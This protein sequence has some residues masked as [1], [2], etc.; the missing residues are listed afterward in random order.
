[1]SILDAKL[2]FDD[3]A[4]LSCSS[5]ETNVSQ[6]VIRL[7]ALSATMKDAWGTE[8]SPDIG[9]GNNGLQV[10]VQVAT[11]FNASNSFTAKIYHHT[12]STFSAGELMGTLVFGSSGAAAPA[13][14]AGS[15]RNFR[16]PAGS[17]D[18][19]LGIQYSCVTGANGGGTVNAWLGLDN[20][21]P[22][23]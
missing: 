13:N 6:S 23:T 10:N 1:M 20:E 9:E 2:E 7:D 19:Y 18:N 14:A 21:T 22:T 11:A 12:T 5:G 17:M 8:I 15:K 16:L 4:T 3:G